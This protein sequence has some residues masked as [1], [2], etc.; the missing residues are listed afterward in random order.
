M[1]KLILT[2]NEQAA[3]LWSDLDDAS[4]GM[5]VRKQ[6]AMLSNAS[7]QMDRTTIFAAALLICCGAAEVGDGSIELSL[8]D[9]TQAGRDFGD[10]TVVAT[11]QR[12]SNTQ[13]H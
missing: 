2:E 10:W 3:A 9:V 4:L 7:A 6:L 1:A 8:Q 12:Q 13:F 5:L 11:R